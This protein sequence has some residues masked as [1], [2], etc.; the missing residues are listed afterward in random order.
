MGKSSLCGVV[1][2]RLVEI[3][4]MYVYVMSVW[5][6]ENSVQSDWHSIQFWVCAIQW[7]NGL[8]IAGNYAI[9]CKG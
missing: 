6:I 3:D 2:K 1:G 4:E 8:V 5:L 9:I 7:L